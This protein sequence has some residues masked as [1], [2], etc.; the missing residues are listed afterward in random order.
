MISFSCLAI[1]IVGYPIYGKF[2]ESP[3]VTMAF[4]FPCDLYLGK[5]FGASAAS[6]GNIAGIVIG[7]AF[8]VK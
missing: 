3:A 4:V 2:V 6:I 1:L 7:I 5:L 8:F